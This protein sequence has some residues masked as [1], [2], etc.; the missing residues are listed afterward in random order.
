MVWRK[1]G[2]QSSTPTRPR[3]CRSPRLRTGRHAGPAPTRRRRGHPL[4]DRH[5][6]RVDGSLLAQL[7]SRRVSRFTP[8]PRKPHRPARSYRLPRP[9]SLRTFRTDGTTERLRALRSLRCSTRATDTTGESSRKIRIC[10]IPQLQYRPPAK[11]HDARQ[12]GQSKRQP[13]PPAYTP[14]TRHP[15]RSAQR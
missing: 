11:P 14:R 12:P 9:R 7:Q 4:L 6:R 1:T 5:L 13:L 10:R 8:K 3:H 15:L 2:K